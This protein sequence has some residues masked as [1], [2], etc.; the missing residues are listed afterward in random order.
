[1]NLYLVMGTHL[2]EL[3]QCLRFLVRSD[4]DAQPAGLLLPEGLPWPEESE[5]WSLQQS[6]PA[7]GSAPQ[8]PDTELSTLW[9]VLDPRL[10]PVHQLEQLAAALK[11][12]D[13]PPA[14][15]ITC[16][17]CSGVEHQPA[18]RVWYEACIYYS[19]IVLLG[20]R[21]DASNSFVRDYQ[22]HFE[23]LCYPCLFLLL[24]GPGNPEQPMEILVPDARRLTQLFDFGDDTVVPEVPGLIIEASCDLDLE[25]AEEDP[26]RP[27]D[28]M[29]RAPL[30]VP[31]VSLWIVPVTSL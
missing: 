17:D 27:E 7:S 2:P 24:K 15:I 1:M 8:I 28:G 6:Y 4:E 21:K 3:R 10:S 12:L 19:D 18:L 9:L 5:P 20:N 29:D 16:V 14:R 30:H 23:K 26:Y 11:V 31:D 25:E 13:L 22:R